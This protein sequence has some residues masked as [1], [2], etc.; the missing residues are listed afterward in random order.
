MFPGLV[1]SGKV[2]KAVPPLYGI[3]VNKSKTQYFAERVD[4]VRY[5]QK[6]Y[7]KK[8][9]VTDYKGKPID[10]TTF[11][12]LLIEN[13][14]Y[15]YDFE[16]ISERHKLSPR[17]LELI[18]MYF[19]KKEKFESLRKKITTEYRF[20][21]NDNVVKRGNGVFIKGLVNDRIETVYVDDRFKDECSILLPA[22]ELAMSQEHMLFLV[23]G[24]KMGLY[25]LVSDAMNSI[26]AVNR[27]KGLGE[28]NP[29]QLQISTMS[30][31]TRTLI[32]YT[33]N[34]LNETVKIIR[35]YDSNKKLILNKIGLVDR[36]DLVGL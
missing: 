10:S 29:S 4:F 20:M 36:G 23:N 31:E 22:V 16:A 30:P 7:Y 11:S 17:L 28:M 1:E 24:K 12:S 33:I 32:Q 35:Q 34:D 2:F 26:G 19:I 21:E 27:F 8:N 14:D 18:L 13:S 3:P 9:K 6:E 25:E 15:M 5:M